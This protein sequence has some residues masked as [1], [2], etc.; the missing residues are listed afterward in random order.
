M[1]FLASAICGPAMMGAGKGGKGKKFSVQDMLRGNYTIEVTKNGVQEE[2]PWKITLAPKNGTNEAVATKT[3]VTQV[4]ENTTATEIIDSKDVKIESVNATNFKVIVD[5]KDFFEVNVALNEHEQVYKY[6][7]E[8]IKYT[9]FNGLYS[10]LTIQNHETKDFTEISFTK[11]RVVAK[12]PLWL[13]LLQPVA[14]IAN[15]WFSSKMKAKQMGAA[16]AQAPA[17]QEQPAEEATE[18]KEPADNEG[19]QAEQKSDDKK[20]D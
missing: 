17:E 8:T 7:N 11:E 15:F 3:K 5:G 2:L 18:K 13:K 12:S 9:I 1:L 20:K 10:V 6:T 19:E 14:L 4:D 16:Q